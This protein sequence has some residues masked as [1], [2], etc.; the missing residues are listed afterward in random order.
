MLVFLGLRIRKLR[1]LFHEYRR[2][3]PNSVINRNLVD[4][5]YS[6]KELSIAQV[7]YH[8][9]QLHLIHTLIQT[10]DCALIP[11]SVQ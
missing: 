2:I 11:H 6:A 4:L 9:A 10:L 8:A 1:F 3:V 7:T 5:I